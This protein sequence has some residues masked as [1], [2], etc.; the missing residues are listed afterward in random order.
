M[1]RWPE[2]ALAFVLAV[3][4]AGAAA[5]ARD[6][7]GV[8]RAATRAEVAAWDIDVRP[9]FQGLPAGSGSVQRGQEVWEAKCASCHGVFGESNQVFHPLVGGTTAKDVASGRVANLAERGYPARTTLMKVATVSTLW[10][11]INRAMPWNA[12]KSL[13]VDEVYASTAYLLNLGGIVDD[14]F[15]LSERT[16]AEAQARLPNRNGMSTA[17]ALWPGTEFGARRAPDV[18]AVRC[19]RDCPVSANV[20]SKLP[21]FALNAHGNLAEQNRKVGPQRG[22]DTAPPA[23]AASAPNP[24]APTV[25]A[26]RDGAAAA[27]LVQKNNCSACHAPDRKLVGPSW[28][29]IGQR[30]AGRADYLA[31]KIRSGG[32]GVWGAIAMPPQ[33]IAESEARA[34]AAW[35]AD[36]P[37]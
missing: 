21:D 17:H 34:I 29:E 15:V 35:L 7:A 6:Y 8:G 5:Q 16:M 1:S 37:R 26:A 32:S 2:F 31:E 20:T 22:I 14:K 19:L 36:A 18:R 30:H 12:P 3:G 33:A 23:V 11:Y 27:T 10:D 9:D 24:A 25:T 28:S 13:T 4:A